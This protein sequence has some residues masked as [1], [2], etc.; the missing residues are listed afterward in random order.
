VLVGKKKKDMTEIAPPPQVF[1]LSEYIVKGILPTNGNNAELYTH[2]LKLPKE[3]LN[4][5]IQQKFRACLENKD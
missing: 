3:T 2:S 4:Y 1:H 5:R